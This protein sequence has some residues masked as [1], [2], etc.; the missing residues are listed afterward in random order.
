MSVPEQRGVSEP[1]GWR[2]TAV[3]AEGRPRGQGAA[4]IKAGADELLVSA[5]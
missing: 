4:E 3:V 2:R 5:E 1:E